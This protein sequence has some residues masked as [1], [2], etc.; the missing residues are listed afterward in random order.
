MKGKDIKPKLQTYIQIQHN[1]G[2]EP[3]VRGVKRLSSGLEVGRFKNIEDDDRLSEL[4]ELGEVVQTPPH[5]AVYSLF[6]I[7]KSFS[8]EK[9]PFLSS[10]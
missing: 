5:R 10:G 7:L 4:C 3:Y 1:Y 9:S 8:P 6:I 2:T